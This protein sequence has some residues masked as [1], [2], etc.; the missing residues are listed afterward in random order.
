MREQAKAAQVVRMN[1][2]RTEKLRQGLPSNR[3]LLTALV[4]QSG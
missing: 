4:G 1:R 3:E 2:E